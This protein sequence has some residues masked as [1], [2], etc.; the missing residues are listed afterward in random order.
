MPYFNYHA[1]AKRLLAEGKLV[2]YYFTA[3]PAR[4]W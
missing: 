4:R 1:T 2:H 3:S